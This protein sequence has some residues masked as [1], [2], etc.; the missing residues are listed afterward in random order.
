[1]DS[2][3]YNKTL[4]KIEVRNINRIIDFFKGL[5]YFA[6]YGRSAL[7]K[8]RLQFS[9]VKF[10]RKQY[11]FKEGEDSIYVYIVVNGDFELEKQVKHIEKKEMNYQRYI[12]SSI[13]DKPNL[14]KSKN[15]SDVDPKVAQFSRVKVLANSN[16]Q[17]NH[18]RIALL[19]KGQMFG[20]QDAFYERP[21]QSSVICRSNGGQLYR[22]TRENFQ[23]L[24]NH[25][26]CWSK[27]TSKYIDQEYLHHR[28]LKNQ[29]KINGI[30]H[31]TKP[32]PKSKN[33]TDRHEQPYMGNIK[34]SPLLNKNEIDKR[35][36]FKEIV[37]GFPFAKRQKLLV[38]S[39]NGQEVIITDKD[40]EDYQN[41]N[42]SQQ[43]KLTNKAR[44]RNNLRINQ[45]SSS[46][47]SKQVV[48]L[49]RSSKGNIKFS[50]FLNKNEYLIS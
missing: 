23:K 22:I 36:T 17:N 28:L 38:E 25:G 30:L 43:I 37:S 29:Q 20:D 3:D 1:M 39:I 50:I 34:G 44:D 46:K 8:I 32:Q 26:D 4:N 47:L 9:R 41:S 16:E 24:K 14:M 13:I 49:D 2:T 7:D 35:H 12:S 48:S 6:N 11:V 33:S 27:I 10:L 5:P 45:D 18:Y 19:S 21:Y 40:V 15:R 42:M 31:S